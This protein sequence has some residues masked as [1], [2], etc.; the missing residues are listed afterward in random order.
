MK[1]LL[2]AFALFWS[3]LCPAEDTSKSQPETTPVKSAATEPTPAKVQSAKPKAQPPVNFEE[4]RAAIELEMK[5]SNVPAVGVAVVDAD[6][7]IWAASLGVANKEKKLAADADT[8]FRIG[9]TSK[10]FVALAILKLQEEGRVKLTDKVRDLVPEVKFENQWESTNPILVGHLLEHTTGWDDMHLPEYAYS[11]PTPVTLKQGLDFHPHSRISRWVPG[12]RM[13]YC[14]SGPPV[15]A[16]IVEKITGQRFEDYVRE[17]FFGPIGMEHAT[18]FADDY[19]AQ[20]GAMLYQNGRIQPYWH[21]SLRPAG[22]INASP[23]DMLQFLQFFLHR[24]VVADKALISE[25][26]L[27]RMET[28]QTT[29]GAVAGTETGYGLANYSSYHRGFR[30]QGHNG[31]VMGGLTELAYCPELGVGHVIMIN[32][33][34]GGAFWRIQ[35]IVKNFEIFFAPLAIN[36][37]QNFYDFMIEF[38]IS[39]E[40][41]SN[42][43]NNFIQKNLM[44]TMKSQVGISDSIDARES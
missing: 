6:G 26:S 15:A 24:G 17:K 29:L 43:Q 7:S 32:C 11:D 42:G 40:S 18:Y 4:L 10:M 12:T 20:H 21:I 36:I 41:D 22:A 23:N 25:Q 3:V 9:S 33:G 28:P 5:K 1:F 35:E 8:Q 16:A 31:G 14:N 44:E 37:T 38:F 19:Y 13:S 2:F 30:Y 27:H 39:K 34:D